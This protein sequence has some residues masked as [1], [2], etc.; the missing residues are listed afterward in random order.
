MKKHKKILI[1]LLSLSL[2]T[3]LSAGTMIVASSSQEGAGQESL[4]EGD[5]VM[6]S[7]ATVTLGSSYKLRA[8]VGN[9]VVRCT[10]STS[11]VDVVTVE[12]N[13][14]VVAHKCGTATVTAKYGE[15]EVTCEVT[16]ALNGNLPV[17]KFDAVDGDEVQID[18]GHT[19]SLSGK[20]RFNGSLYEDVEVRYT[21]KDTSLGTIDEDG[22]FTPGKEGTTTVTAT[23]SWRDIESEFLTQ[24]ITI[25]VV[26]S[27]V[28]LMNESPLVPDVEVDTVATWKGNTYQNTQAFAAKLLVN[29]D[30]VTPTITVTDENVA[31]YDKAKKQIVG[32]TRGET[33]AVISYVGDGVD[34]EKAI[35]VSVSAPVAAWDDKVEYF[36]AFKGNLID[37]NGK[38]ILT[39]AFGAD[40]AV[41]AAYQGDK[42]LDLSVS[43]KILGVETSSTEMTKT[44]LTIYG[45]KYGYTVDVSGY[46]MVIE[47]A[48]D[49]VEAFHFNPNG[50][51]VRKGYYYLKQ[52]VDM[53]NYDVNGDKQTGDHLASDSINTASSFS[54]GE[55]NP[56]KGLFDGNGK[57]ITG[58][59]I[60]GGCGLFGVM[61]GGMVKDLALVDVNTYGSVGYLFGLTCHNSTVENVY[62]SLNFKTDN[63]TIK[64]NPQ[65]W[66]GKQSGFGLFGHRPASNDSNSVVLKNVIIEMTDGFTDLVGKEKGT[67]GL[68]SNDPFTLNGGTTQPKFTNVYFLVPTA[69]NGRV[70]PMCQAD[71]LTGSGVRIC[72]TVYASN[73]YTEIEDGTEVTFDATT[74]NPVVGTNGNS[75]PDNDGTVK[76]SKVYHYDN[77]FH[78]ADVAA[79]YAAGVT[80][81]GNWQVVGNQLTFVK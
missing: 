23:A 37:V 65:N 51:S 47:S 80:Q 30:E 2:L 29:G 36:S 16:V 39:E 45:E 7:A 42:A 46:T 70:M 81:V 32:Q 52:D 63:A 14:E 54:Q 41:M 4:L 5:L 68:F 34:Y 72:Q 27:V 66:L 6:E 43:G 9:E 58:L 67:V 53:T 24:K 78:Y 44:V 40:N 31:Y 33:T 71:K 75:F 48:A 18:R 38:N 26:P 19:L 1:A 8:R 79:M 11:N 57:K 17:F 62:I 64:N 25:K 21:L 22:V 56:F 15:Q 55:K 76:K 69:S 60:G 28:L 73:I 3:G 12:G 35:P 10:W 20:V 50:S 49:V 74:F 77:T 13:G 61:D 59:K